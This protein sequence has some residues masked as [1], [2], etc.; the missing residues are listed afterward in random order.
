MQRSTLQREQYNGRAARC[1][2]AWHLTTQHIVHL[3]TQRSTLQ[4]SAACCDAA[5]H[6]ATQ[7]DILEQSA[8]TLIAF[9]SPIQQHGTLG[10]LG[11]E[12]VECTQRMAQASEGLC[13]R[14]LVRAQAGGVGA[15]VSVRAHAYLYARMHARIHSTHAHTQP[16]THMHAC[17][18]ARRDATAGGRR[19]AVPYERRPAETLRPISLRALCVSTRVPVSTPRNGLS[20]PSST[21]QGSSPRHEHH[22]CVDVRNGT[23]RIARALLSYALN[24]LRAFHE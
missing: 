22:Y 11:T 18:H 3:A 5:Q 4:R 20:T 13:V 12:A 21:Q 10:T 23:N 9:A 1:N 7:R 6:V 14:E 24:S 19:A 2:A 16:R 8:T 15:P 17:T